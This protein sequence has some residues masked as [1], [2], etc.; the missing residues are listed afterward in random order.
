MELNTTM[1]LCHVSP[2]EVLEV[3]AGWEDDNPVDNEFSSGFVVRTNNGFSYIVSKRNHRL[4]STRAITRRFDEE[5]TFLYERARHWNFNKE[6][7]NANLPLAKQE[8]KYPSTDRK[9]GGE[10]CS[11]PVVRIQAPQPGA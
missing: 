8:A 6:E 5:P 1:S 2:Y 3:I 9:S 4:R 11:R 7:L 10:A